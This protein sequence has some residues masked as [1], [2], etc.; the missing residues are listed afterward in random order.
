M[1]LP[2][3]SVVGVEKAVQARREAVALLE[4][5]G[6]GEDFAYPV[7]VSLIPTGIWQGGPG[8][9]YPTISLIPQTSGTFTVLPGFEFS[10]RQ[11]SGSVTV[12]GQDSVTLAE[13]IVTP[14]AGIAYMML[15][16]RF[17]VRDSASNSSW[18][19]APLYGQ[20]GSTGLSRAPLLFGRGA[21]VLP[22][23]TVVTVDVTATIMQNVAVVGLVNI[24]DY[25]LQLV[26]SGVHRQAR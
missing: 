22:P 6:V 4:N 20:L 5:Q 17:R 12:I 13:V 21:R 18:S 3:A 19:N 7:D 11:I 24:R 23:A 2:S 16:Y 25:R 15:D 26:F 14:M 10:V 9:L 1:D 8:P